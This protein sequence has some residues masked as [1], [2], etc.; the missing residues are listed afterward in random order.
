MPL[1]IAT[2]SWAVLLA[3]GCLVWSGIYIN[4]SRFTGLLK[5]GNLSIT[6]VD[7]AACLAPGV[8][9]GAWHISAPTIKTSRDAFLRYALKADDPI[10][11]S[12]AG[13]KGEDT[14]WV[15]HLV[16]EIHPRLQV[17]RGPGDRKL[18]EGPA[19]IAFKLSAKNGPYAGW[20]LAEGAPMD[21]DQRGSSKRLTLVKEA[22]TAATLYYEKSFH[23][24]TSKG[25]R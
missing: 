16:A 7:G 1:R 15:F 14:E 13:G 22:G 12:L 10:K 9:Q 19:G 17:N 6:S 20:Y 24:V 5:I 8:D 21:A 2:L 23:E 18:L 3:G 4:S 25:R 11:V